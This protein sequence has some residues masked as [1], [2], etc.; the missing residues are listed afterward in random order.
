MHSFAW[1]LV[2]Q[3]RL[4]YRLILD[5]HRYILVPCDNEYDKSCSKSMWRANG[6]TYYTYFNSIYEYVFG[7]MNRAC[8]GL[9]QKLN[10]VVHDLVGR[11]TAKRWKCTKVENIQVT[12]V[13]PGGMQETSC[14]RRIMLAVYKRLGSQL[15][16]YSGLAP[17]FYVEF[18]LENSYYLFNL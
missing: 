6:I 1:R 2:K 9:W 5:S 4:H 10:A 12:R 18:I 16:R 8:K 15:L 7:R 14:L 13:S 17:E 3:F 11:Q